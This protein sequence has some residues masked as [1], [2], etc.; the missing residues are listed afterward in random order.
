MTNP[1]DSLSTVVTNRDFAKGAGTTLLARLGA[2]FETISQPLYVLMFGLAGYGLYAVLWAAITLV[3]NILDLGMPAALQRVV[4]QA[5]SPHDE[6]AALRVALFIGVIPSVLFALVITV[7]ARAIAPLFNAADADAAMLVTAI[8]I[9][10]WSLP[11]WA[12][13]EVATAALRS[14]RMFGAEIRL[15]LLW[16]QVI[17]LVIAVALYVVGFGTMALFYAHLLSLVLTCLLALRLL[18]RYFDLRHFFSVRSAQPMFTEMLGAGLAVLPSNIVARLFSDGPPLLLNTLLVGSAGA[19]SAALYVI[20]RKISSIVQLVRTAFNYVLAPLASAASKGES[21]QVARIYGFVTRLSFAL[22]LPLGAVLAGG[23]SA[24]L[25]LFGPD[26]NP[27]LPALVI[28]TGARII[29]AVIGGGAPIQQ[30]TSGFRSQ[31]AGSLGGLVTAAA[32]CLWLMPAWGVTGMAIAVGAG[33]IVSVAIPLY[34][35]HVIAELHPFAA[36]FSHVM[37]RSA[38]IAVVT[39][40]IVLLI[41][42]LRPWSQ[43]PMLLVALLTALWISARFALPLEDRQALGSAATKLKLV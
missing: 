33:V 17:R 23:G 36:P 28:L 43:L 22:A 31:L 30:V 25:R 16:E 1:S 4:P 21:G 24:I 6:L 40:M 38:L 26:A 20:A 35:L 37:I 9:Y 14:K 34:Q 42:Q 27:A 5:A 29:E 2:V 15:R 18:G 39:L 19:V 41:A 11:L 32:I 12:F 13:V 3:E 7:G 10:A 8:E